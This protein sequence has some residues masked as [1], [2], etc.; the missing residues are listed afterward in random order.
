MK[1]VGAHLKV[2]EF[3]EDVFLCQLNL[4]G[5]RLRAPTFETLVLSFNGVLHDNA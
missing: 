4:R 3:T 5:G 2:N 1:S